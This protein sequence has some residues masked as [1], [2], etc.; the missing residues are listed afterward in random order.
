MAEQRDS[1]R[2]I[3]I[4]KSYFRKVD[5]ADSSVVDLFSHD[6]AVFFPGL[7]E[8]RGPEAF[9]KFASGIR[10]QIEKI[11]HFPEEYRYSPSGSSLYVEGHEKGEFQ[12]GTKF[13]RN[14]FVVACDFSPEYKIERMYIYTNPD[15][16]EERK[17]RFK[18]D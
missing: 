14:L 17:S 7:G 2:M 18:F 1:K 6:L 4:A 15:F 13:G 11:E 9:L 16:A 12:D 8:I 3:E 5:A 10:G